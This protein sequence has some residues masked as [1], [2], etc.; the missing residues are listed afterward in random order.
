MKKTAGIIIALVIVVGAGV[1]LK[2]SNSK[3]PAQNETNNTYVVNTNTT[4]AVNTS[5]T[6]TNTTTTTKPAVTTTVKPKVAG[7]TMSDVAM[8]ST[9]SSCWTIVNGSVYDVTNWINKHPGGSRA[10]MGMCGKDASSAFDNQHGGQAR[11]ESELAN[12]KIGI[13][14]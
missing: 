8:H 14:N 3:T 9:A 13:L 2:N 7:Y 1:F 6:T 4:P 11:P 12:F 5:T 10:I